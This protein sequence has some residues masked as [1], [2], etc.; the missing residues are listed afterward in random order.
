[1]LLSLGCITSSAQQYF[2]VRDPLHSFNSILTSVVESN[3]KYFCTGVCIDSVNDLGNGT[4]YTI[5]GIKFAV[6]DHYGNKLSD[7]VYQRSDRNI[8]SWYSEL[9]PQPNGSF[10]LAVDAIEPGTSP[11][12][13]NSIYQFDSLGNATLIA[14]HTKPVCSGLNPNVDLWRLVDF[15]PDGF[16]NWLMLST[17]SC[18]TTTGSNV[19]A[20][21]LLTKLDS[22][23]NVIWHKHYFT[24]NDY[25]NIAS[26]LLVEPNGY[27]IAGGAN[28]SNWVKKNFEFHARIF[29]TD[30]A[31]NELWTYLSPVTRLTNT[32]QD[33]IKTQDGG[34]VFCGQGGGWELLSP[35]GVNSTLFWSAWVEKIDAAGNY[36]WSKKPY[37]K[38]YYTTELVSVKEAADGRLMLFG[39]KYEPD[40]LSTTQWD[41]H[42]RGWFLTLS[43]T[44]DSLRE[45]VYTNITTCNDFN[46]F[47]DV[48]QTS[49]GGYIMV[50]E[51]TDNCHTFTAPKQ[52][53]WLIKVDSNGCM[54]ATDPQC[55]PTDIPQSPE[56]SPTVQVY[57][58]P[59]SDVLHVR[60]SRVPSVAAAITIFDLYGRILLSKTITQ[61]HT[62]ISLQNLPSGLYLYKITEGAVITELGKLTK[63]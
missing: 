46:A 35:S 55:Q 29:R 21:M 50:G 9:F 58:N 23:F 7:T 26:K 62:D 45:R 14:E 49:D 52:R 15:K 33:I 53:G 2:N 63:Q 18:A 12:F 27:I 41:L 17:V 8:L 51:S 32:I 6:F 39:R 56:V 59:V 37:N 5:H 61:P 42:T 34:Y 47:H 1:M 16:G 28:N 38:Y 36:L 25:H 40:S 3:N 10:L 30:T 11:V 24:A 31:G 4:H 57:P 44:G 20:D 54:S 13:Y 48:K 60:I 22:S 43:A 19:N